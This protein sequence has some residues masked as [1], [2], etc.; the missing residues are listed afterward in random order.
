[1]V[2][3]LI[4]IS[5]DDKE[6]VGAK[7]AN[8]ANLIHSGFPVP[9]GFVVATPAYFQFLKENNLIREV[10][11]LLSTVN[12]DVPES[13]SQVSSHIRKRITQAP[14]S[15]SLLVEID[16]QYKKLGSL[17][18]NS[19]VIVS[20]SP[21]INDLIRP[22]FY[23][24]IE[25]ISHV[26]GEANLILAIK[27]VW[28]MLFQPQTLIYRYNYHLDNFRSGVGV[29]VQKM[30]YPDNS[31]IIY[32]VDPSTGDKSKIIVEAF[33]GSLHIT[34][35]SHVL[36]DHYELLKPSFEIVKN[37]V[38]KQEMYLKIQKSGDKIL[39]V[40]SFEVM[41]PKLEDRQIKILAKLG[42]QLEK[43][44]FFPQEIHWALEEN[45][46][47]ILKTQQ[48]TTL[49]SDDRLFAKKLLLLLKGKP[50]SSSLASGVVRKIQTNDDYNKVSQ[51]DVLVVPQFISNHLPALKKASALISESEEFDPTYTKDIGIPII[52][53]AK[54]ATNIL[55]NGSVVTVDGVRGEIYKG[56]Y[57]SSSPSHS[58]HLYNS[59]LKTKTNIFAYLSSIPT[60]LSIPVEQISGIVLHQYLNHS[61]KREYTPVNALVKRI[62]PVCQQYQPLPI[63]YQLTH[64]A[65][66]DERIIESEIEA[67]KIL[68]EKKGYR[69]LWVLL[70]AIQSEPEL[71]RLKI[72]L[73]NADLHRS[74]T[75]KQFLTIEA[76]SQIV[77]LEK[78]IQ[79][80]IDGVVLNIEAISKHTLGIEKHENPASLDEQHPAVLSLIQQAHNLLSKS[81]LQLNILFTHSF[82][83]ESLLEKLVRFKINSIS[84][85]PDNRELIRRSLH[86]IEK[87]V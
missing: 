65:H 10:N 12:Y 20:P 2:Y 4:D 25:T 32:T 77:L 60:Q 45:K 15:D 72:L 21:E 36:P 78:F 83:R 57:H 24:Q 53:G 30:V 70:P 69:N 50:V 73:S 58:I 76:P 1:M 46:Y 39:N 33:Y 54:D 8:L 26:H 6:L 35:K 16:K 68:R 75:F 29:I 18:N 56:S 34:E 38:V 63:I 55:Q 41:K 87:N 48:M 62:E 9:L 23:G 74:P 3:S 59:T 67:I 84:V 47:Y 61:E 31:G 79:N 44:S 27:K 71:D 7:A 81:H 5:K 51:G 22:S 49:T 85:L 28:A 43:Y 40:P 42:Q 37:E 66:H 64:I 17:L 80:G 52:I 86:T 14:I 19:L 11:H 13:V 82:I